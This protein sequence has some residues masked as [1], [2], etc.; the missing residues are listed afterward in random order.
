MQCVYK[1]MIPGSSKF[2]I[3]SSVHL[4]SRTRRHRSDLVRNKHANKHLQ[5]SFNK[6]GKKFE[7]EVLEEIHEKND[8]DVREQFYID[9][10]GFENL[11][12][13]CPVAYSTRGRKASVETIEKIRQ[14]STMNV[15][16]EFVS[17]WDGR[18]RSVEQRKKQSLRQTGRVMS[19]STKAKLSVANAQWKRSEEHLAALNNSWRGSHHTEEAKAKIA[20]ANKGRVISENTKQKMRDNHHLS[21]TVVQI[22][23]SSLEVINTYPSVCEAARSLNIKGSGVGNCCRGYS[24][25]SH[26]FMWRYA[27]V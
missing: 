14:I 8:L 2:Y 16:S 4:K 5:N 20:V 7:I 18:K 24:K 23:I 21:K 15:K 12:N 3:G 17:Y 10:Y 13:Q 25:T 19:G 11:L 27:D 26:G 1:L 6:H 9:L 22:D